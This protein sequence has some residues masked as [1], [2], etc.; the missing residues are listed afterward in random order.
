MGHVV[1]SVSGRNG[2]GT[3]FFAHGARRPGWGRDGV[4]AEASLESLAG[5]GFVCNSGL[6]PLLRQ[7]PIMAALSGMESV[8]GGPTVIRNGFRGRPGPSVERI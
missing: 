4:L 2:G 7:L 8:A 5:L 6:G 3:D 1:Y